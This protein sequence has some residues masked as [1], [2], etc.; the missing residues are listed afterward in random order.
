MKLTYF[1]LQAHLTKQLASLYLISGEELLLKQDVM[2]MLRKAAKKAGFSERSRFS[3]DTH[4]DADQLYATLHAGS[5][6]AEKRLIELDFCD[7]LPNKAIGKVLQ[8]YVDHPAPDTVVLLEMGK[9]DSKIAKTS[10]YKALEKAGMVIALWPIPR[11]QLPQW[12]QQ[13]A[14]KYKL[15]FNRDAA[16]LLV[17]Y[18][19]GNLVAAAQTIEKIYLLRPTKAIDVELLQTFLTNESKFTIFDL[20]DSLVAGETAR[21]LHILDNLKAD[22]IEPILI[23]W[24]ITRELRLLA[25]YSQQLAQGLGYEQLFQ[26][27]RVFFRRQ[28]SIRRFLSKFTAADCWQQLAHAADID[29]MI[30]GVLTGSVWDSLQLFCLRLG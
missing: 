15:Q 2:H 22:G 1:Q 23:L 27:N 16:T 25:D 18:V 6:F 3:H 9:I 7:H 14:Q 28:T 19:E 24:A 10:W 12:I 17:D 21:T 11:E 4:H 26:K 20:V 30:K 5:L 29:R 8:E 13:R